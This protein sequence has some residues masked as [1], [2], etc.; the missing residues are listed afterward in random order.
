MRHRS[1]GQRAASVVAAI[2]LLMSFGGLLVDASPAFASCEPTL[3]ECVGGSDAMQ[4]A[5]VAVSSVLGPVTPSQADQGLSQF[6]PPQQQPQA[7]GIV[8][9]DLI[10]GLVAVLVQVIL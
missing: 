3:N 5:V 4:Q 2:V 1:R 8:E 7:E 6:N 10:L 9:Y